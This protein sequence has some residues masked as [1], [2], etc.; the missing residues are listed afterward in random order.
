MRM[1]TKMFQGFFWYLWCI[2]KLRK[3][4][5][6]DERENLVGHVAG[7]T[8]VTLLKWLPS[9]IGMWLILGYTGL[10]VC[11]IIASVPSWPGLDC[12][13]FLNSCKT[14]RKNVMV[15]AN[16]VLKKNSV[17]WNHTGVPSPIWSLFLCEK[18]IKKDIRK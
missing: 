7:L 3:E 2:D 15:I 10:N 5:D 18:D 1:Q 4:Q 6:L 14:A 17:K 11:S 8:P 12:V 16:T 9:F 13:S